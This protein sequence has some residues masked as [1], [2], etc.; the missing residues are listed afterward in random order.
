MRIVFL[1]N[2][3]ITSKDLTQ[4][5]RDASG[6]SVNPSDEKNLKY[7]T[8]SRFYGVKNQNEN[9]S[10]HIIVSMY[11]GGQDR[12]MTV[13]VYSHLSTTEE[14]LSWFGAAFSQ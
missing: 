8:G 11:G 7:T 4:L 1:R 3:K 9:M 12:N 2:K 13:N 14:I 6:L 5:L 10:V